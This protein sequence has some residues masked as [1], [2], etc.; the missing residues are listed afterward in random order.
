MY[1][2]LTDAKK[3]EEFIKLIKE[4]EY[5]LENP[6]IYMQFLKQRILDSFSLN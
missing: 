5:V 1:N 2:E 3:V 6:E 4:A